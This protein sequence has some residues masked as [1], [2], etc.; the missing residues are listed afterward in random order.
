VSAEVLS[1][2]ANHIPKEAIPLVF[3]GNSKISLAAA[4]LGHLS[5]GRGMPSYE[6]IDGSIINRLNLRNMGHKAH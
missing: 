3:F 2:S 1:S 4:L 6:V 5:S